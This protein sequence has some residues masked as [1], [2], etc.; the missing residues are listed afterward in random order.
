MGASDATSID[1]GSSSAAVLIF[2]DEAK[3][4]PR[5]IWGDTLG[6]PAWDGKV[7]PL[8]ELTSLSAR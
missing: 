4:F 2:D 6:E 3:P 7:V 8:F 5:E 1:L